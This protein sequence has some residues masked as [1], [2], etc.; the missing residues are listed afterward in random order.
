MCESGLERETENWLLLVLVDL[1]ITN[2]IFCWKGL[3]KLDEIMVMRITT[4]LFY[5]ALEKTRQPGLEDP[6]SKL[7]EASPIFRTN[8]PFKVFQE[9]L[10]APWRSWKKATAHYPFSWDGTRV[11]SCWDA[12]IESPS[13][14]GKTKMGRQLFGSGLL[15]GGKGRFQ[16]AQGRFLPKSKPVIGWQG[17]V[18]TARYAQ[19]HANSHF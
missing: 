10:A 18:Q 2:K 1:F 4:T 8:F 19:R 17:L 5:K 3:I 9:S 12:R 13:P 11:K 14:C 15:V 16:A 6:G 7:T